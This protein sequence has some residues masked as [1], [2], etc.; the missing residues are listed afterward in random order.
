MPTCA[1]CGGAN[2]EPARFCSHCGDPLP[3]PSV[4]TARKVVTALFSDV[5]G[6][7]A[8]GDRLDPESLQQLI[9]E[10]FDEADRII[11]HHGGTVEKFMG[12]E[13]MAVFGVPT[14]HE[15]DALRAARA[16]LELRDTLVE[17]NERLARRWGVRLAVHTGVN[18]GE[19]IIG[20][21]P[22]GEASTSGE[23]VNAAQRLEA[24]ARPGEVLIGDETARLIRGAADLDRVDG[25]SG[26]GPAAAWR[27]AAIAPT[28]GGP[29]ERLEAPFVGREPELDALRRAFERVVA[30]R[31]PRQ[32]TILGPAGIGKSRLVAELLA[33]LGGDATAVVGRCLPYGEGITYWPVVE[34]VR[35]LSGATTEAA[36]ASL[37]G[38]GAPNEESRLVAS[39]VARAAGLASGA[40]PVEEAQ[41]G[42]RRLLEDVAGREPLIVVVEDI[43]WAEPTLLDLLEHLATRANDV[44]LLLICLA[45]PEL[46]D[47]RPS[48]LA[49]AGDRG[50][51]VRLD[52]LTPGVAGELLERLSPVGD[53]GADERAEI[54][55]AH[56]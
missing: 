6:F 5:S 29:P 23:A 19:A 55:R 1:R 30:A 16:A 3:D 56:V 17:L 4:A 44:P 28:A 33:E 54:G 15:D 45:R 10:W 47:G 37:L 25:A 21:A 22:G 34:I 26:A 53:D 50:S 42:V 12:D 39:R 14:V 46:L 36:L 35:Q 18:T 38:G 41:W 49:S 31:T 13:V 51:L 2:A 52:A 32:I 9:G 8:L 20:L 40:L 11:A 27:L 43:H 24:A 7:T 48:W